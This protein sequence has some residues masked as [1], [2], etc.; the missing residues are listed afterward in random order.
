MDEWM[1]NTNR[2]EYEVGSLIAGNVI[3][4]CGAIIAGRLW[5]ARMALPSSCT[6][7]IHICLIHSYHVFF[8]P[9]AGLCE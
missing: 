4:K 5:R 1:S 6:I 8:D 3:R 7:I 2:K 9:V